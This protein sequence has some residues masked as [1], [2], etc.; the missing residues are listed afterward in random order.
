MDILFANINDCSE[1]IDLQKLSYKQEAEIYNDYKIPPLTQTIEE[2]KIEFNNCTV[3]KA[4]TCD[5]IV[6]SVRACIKN[7]TCYIGRLIVH[8]DHQNK[9]IGTQLMNKIEKHFEDKGIQ[10]YELF[11]GQKSRKNIYLY[12]KLGYKIFKT[13]K[14]SSKVNIVYLE[15]AI[16]SGES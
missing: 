3:L 11:T 8:P 10:K 2:L 4:V 5:I 13:E 14:I 12:Q 6:G 9:G 16:C 7:K 1:I 15:K